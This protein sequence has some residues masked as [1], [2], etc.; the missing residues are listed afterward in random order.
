[1]P[2]VNAVIKAEIDSLVSS[3]TSGDPTEKS[4]EATKSEFSQGLAN[5]I[6]NAIKSATVN[7]IS[8]GGVTPGG[9]ASGPGT[10]TL[11]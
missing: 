8:V 9:G 10:G 7:V 2:I 1:M 6:E 5:V 11:S 3:L 4:I